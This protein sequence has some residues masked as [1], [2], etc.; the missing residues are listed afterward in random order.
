MQYNIIYGTLI[1]TTDV[2]TLAVAKMNS[3]IESDHENDLLEIMLDAAVSEV[4]NYIDS[5]VRERNMSIQL[6]E[7]PDTF[8]LPIYPVNSIVSVEYVDESGATQTVAVSDYTFYNTSTGSK[9]KFTWDSAPSLEE[10]NEF[11]ITIN[12]TAGWSQEDMPAEI[13][14]AV[15]LR[16]SFNE[17]Y[18]E[19]MPTSVNRTFHNAL[20]PLKRWV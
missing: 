1:N 4:E 17:R 14:K 10:D 15:L 18:R 20:R 2:V 16:F 5:P 19:E 8:E 11:P 13:K 7:W 9:I 12:C 3:N 6:N